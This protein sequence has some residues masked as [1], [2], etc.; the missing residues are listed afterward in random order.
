[1]DG[2]VGGSE[3]VVFTCVYVRVYAHAPACLVEP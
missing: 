3:G 2:N 1:M